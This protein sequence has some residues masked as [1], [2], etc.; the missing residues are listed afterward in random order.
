[1]KLLVVGDIVGR[2]GLDRL[3]KSLSKKIEEENIDFCIVNGENSAGG[4]GLRKKEY[5]EIMSYGA[6]VI[7]M[8]NHLYYRKEMANE[9]I[10]LPR[11]L[12]P[13]NITNLN[14][15]HNVL[16]SKNGINLGVINLIGRAEMGENFTKNTVS[17]FEEAIKQI[18]DLNAKKADYIIV[19]FHAEATAEKIALGQYLK[20][21]VNCVF[22]TH[23]HVQTADETILDSGMA[24]ITD[25]GMVGPKDSVL[26]LKKEIAIERFLTNSYIKYE[27]S[28]N[29]AMFN[30]LIVEFDNNTKKAV[31][32][33]RINE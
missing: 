23:T 8:G 12:I 13:A 11:L 28:T 19:D 3:K 10:K 30:G 15:N 17:P 25:V 33:K 18:D 2:P 26:G 1:M 20:D 31:S 22:G 24:Y 21:K 4:K 27:C 9:Y 5:D 32:I 29:E 6:D 14:G 16:V 7:T